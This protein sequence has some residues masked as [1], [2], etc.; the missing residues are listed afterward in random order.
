MDRWW[1]LV[2]MATHLVNFLFWTSSIF[3]ILITEDGSIADFRSI[4]K[5]KVKVTL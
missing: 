2:N 3:L 5:V 4:V 1:D